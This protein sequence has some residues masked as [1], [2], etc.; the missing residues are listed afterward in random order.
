MKKLRIKILYIILSFFSIH[1]L[2]AQ[3]G[4]L[5]ESYGI[6]GVVRHDSMYLGLGNSILLPDGKTMHVGFDYFLS[7]AMH[8][9]NVN[10]SLDTTFGTHGAIHFNEDSHIKGDYVDRIALQSDGK[11][12][13]SAAYINP[14]NLFYVAVLRFFPDGGIDSSFGTNGMDTFIVGNYITNNYAIAI[15]P[16]GKIILGGD[17]IPTSGD[18]CTYLVRLMPDGGFDSTFGTNGI[19]QKKYGLFYDGNCADLLLQPDGKIIKGITYDY[20]SGKGQFQLERYNT[21]G[22]IDKSYGVNGVA[23][24][25]FGLGQSGLWSTKMQDIAFQPDGKIVCTGYSGK[26]ESNNDKL[27]MAVCR[28]MPDGTVD[29]GFG[30]DGGIIYYFNIQVLGHSVAVQPDGKILVGGTSYSSVSEYIIRLLENGQLDP[31]FGENGLAE[32]YLALGNGEDSQI[33]LFVLDNGKILAMLGNMLARFNN[34]LILAT[35][36]K[37]VKAVQDKT[38]VTISWET[39]NES[40]T[41]SYSIERSSNATEFVSIATVPAKGGTENKYSYT[42]QHPLQGIAYYRIKEN[43]L[44]G[45]ATYSNTLKVIFESNTLALYPNPAKSTLT[46]TGLSKLYT[47]T[48][49][50]T[51]IHGREIL[52]QKTSNSSELTLTIRSLAQG[53]YFVLIEQNGKVDKLRFIKE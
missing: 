6:N 13:I 16:D 32:Q 43:A 34:D 48:I 49:R 53:S 15:Q 1:Q 36:F 30:T 11:F 10:G 31:G 33:D 3:A 2:Q 45:T 46:I 39:L 44:N 26:D 4:Y 29:A 41:K 52:Q 9:F 40:G 38:G 50:I 7:V 23:S 22:S 19:V 5:D 12:V 51:D 18:D 42:D 37:N 8:R 21:D 35:H 28:F 24:Y 17:F 20:Y 27:G 25:T 47:A 14:N